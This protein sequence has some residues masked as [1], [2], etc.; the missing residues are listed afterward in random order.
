LEHS[1]K[2]WEKVLEKGV[3]EAVQI[4][5]NQFGFQPGKST[6]GAIFALRQ[7]QEKYSAEEKELFHVFVDLEK[8]F[9]RVPR[10]AIRWAL[11]RQLV[12]ER[13]IDQVMALYAQSTSKVD[14][15]WEVPEF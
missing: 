11:R 12:P 7:V 1:F 13:L 8:A 5:G 15:C 10:Q 2:I 4:A 6:T 3:R 9:D 14:I